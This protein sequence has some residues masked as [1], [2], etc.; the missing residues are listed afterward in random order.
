M[1]FLV[2]QQ[3]PPALARFLEGEGHVAQHVRDVNLKE[4]DDLIVWQYASE[5]EMVVISKDEDLYFLALLSK[6]TGKLV[7][8]KIGNCRKRT[9]IEKFRSQLGNIIAALESGSRIV[10]IR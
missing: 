1:R 9:L 10:E 3:L 5:R 7:W 6:S 2:D 8:V 4:A